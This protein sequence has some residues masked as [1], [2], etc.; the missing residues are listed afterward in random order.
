MNT[1]TLDADARTNM[2]KLLLYKTI[3][4]RVKQVFK[5]GCNIQINDSGYPSGT[6]YIVTIQLEA[7]KYFYA[8]DLSEFKNIAMKF[9]GM[10]VE[11][12]KQNTTQQPRLSLYF[13]MDLDRYLQAVIQSEPNKI[14]EPK[15]IIQKKHRQQFI[16]IF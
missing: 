3:E 2:T 13:E 4:Q 14:S 10:R 11:Q 5:I 15:Q 1:I 12:N 9:I 16:G 7:G 8:Q 6:I